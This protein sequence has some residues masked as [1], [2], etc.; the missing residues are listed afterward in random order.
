MPSRVT[1]Y[2]LGLSTETPEDRFVAFWT[3]LEAL[4]NSER[5]FP[6]DDER[7]EIYQEI[8]EVADEKLSEYPDY[9]R[10]IKQSMGHSRRE[11]TTETLTR[12]LTS[13]TD[14]SDSDI[15]DL[16]GLNTARNDIV[17]SGERVDEIGSKAE[18]ARKYLRKVLD[19]RLSDAYTEVLET[20]TVDLDIEPNR[21]YHPVIDKD[22]WL[23]IVFEGERGKELSKREIQKRAFALLPNIHEIAKIRPED[24]SGWMEPLH[25]KPDD[26]YQYA[27]MPEWVTPEVDAI[28]TYLC[29]AG[30]VPPEAIAHNSNG[31][32]RDV[33]LDADRA[34]EICEKLR[35]YHVVESEGEY[36]R[37]T[38][39]G[40]NCVLGRVNPATL[41]EL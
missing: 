30:A 21:T 29:Q 15:S 9:R 26:Q 31:E 23:E 34:A 24:Y 2:N 6:E 20:D 22:E 4:E 33:E 32:R 38:L 25:A 12:V 41:T 35:Q 27:P 13:E 14:L 8:K 7:E 28:M 18:T 1:W 39:D 11:F 3:G 36:Y 37:C 16:S 17:H 10:R 5:V 19:N 40:Q